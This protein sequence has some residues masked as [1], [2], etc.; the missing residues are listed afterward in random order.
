M[1]H[2]F[3]VEPRRQR[4]PA[5]IGNLVGGDEPRPERA[6]AGK[7]L[8]RRDGEFLIVAHAAVDEAGV[9]GDV[10]ERVLGLD[11]ASGFADDDG[12]FAFEIKIVRHHRPDHLAVMADQRVGEAHEHARLLRQLAPGLGGVRR[13]N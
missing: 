4:Q 2:L 13:G 6:G 8:A 12:E 9:A 5:R 11:V 3:A 10:I 7:V 1:L